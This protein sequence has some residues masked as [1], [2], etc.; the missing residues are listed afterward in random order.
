MSTTTSTRIPLELLFGCPDRDKPRISPDGT[1]CAFLAPDG[2]HSTVWLAN[3]DSETSVPTIR[4][5]D[6]P[7]TL[8]KWAYTSRHLLIMRDTNGDEAWQL[9]VYD[10]VAGTTVNATPFPNA[11]VQ[12]VKLSPHKPTSALLI[13]NKEDKALYD[14]YRLDLLTLQLTLIERNP[15]NVKTWYTDTQLQVR[16]KVTYDDACAFHL[17]TRPTLYDEWQCQ[18]T[19]DA[20]STFTSGLIN[21]PGSDFAHFSND[22]RYLYLTD[23]GDNETSSLIKL[24]THTGEGTT[25]LHDD[26][27][28]IR[29]APGLDDLILK[30]IPL[31]ST[32]QD[33]NHDVTAFS[34]YRDRLQWRFF[35]KK[36]EDEFAVWQHD[37]DVDWWISQKL[38][39]NCYV[40][41]TCSDTQP[42]TYYHFDATSGTRHLLCESRH[43]LKEFTLAPTQP[44][45]FTS[46]DGLTIHGYL[47]MP[48]GV[49][50][51]PLMLKVHGG[52]WARDIWTYQPDVQ[53]LAD[54]GYGCLQINY[55]GSTGYG[56]NFVNSGNCEWGKKMLD[57][58]EDGYR[59]IID[60]KISWEGRVGI[61]GRSYGGYAALSAL[62][63]RPHL[64]T[65]GV[66]EVPPTHIPTLIESMPTYWR[67]FFNN[68]HH[69]I[70][71]PEKQREILEKY[72]PALHVPNITAPVLLTHG[73]HDVRVVVQ[74]TE[75]MLKALKE[76]N[77]EFTF[78]L[79]EDEGHKSTK[80]DN[81]I[82]YMRTV[83]Q[84]LA[85]NLPTQ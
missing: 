45:S 57:D 59:W 38:H 84:F 41:G 65:C 83:S 75:M 16:A 21:A 71:H 47:T 74:Q 40:I 31:E 69:R 67:A 22:G 79:F 13:L 53:M 46:R 76:H 1:R 81:I 61:I 51:A 48:V 8:F 37:T 66:A 27:Y 7:I 12:E 55:R 26:V 29:T 43:E 39:N 6:R 35:D 2:K 42:A 54:Q 24:D 18:H 73:L 32:L 11:R 14:V 56:K 44:V 30:Q 58:L 80:P 70:G 15:G 78:M 3:Q 23:A 19:W 36:T 60:Q 49:E 72:S 33:K 10:I 25:L 28:D 4:N 17:L 20:D 34:Y 5:P 52:P 63:L 62:T 68:I 50:R 9:H 77:K 85:K 64:F 82:A